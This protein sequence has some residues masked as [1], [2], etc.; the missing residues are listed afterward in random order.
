MGKKGTKQKYFAT[1][2][3][4]H[5]SSLD[6]FTQGFSMCT[7][8]LPEK[9]IFLTAL[10]FTLSLDKKHKHTDTH[11]HTDGKSCDNNGSYNKIV[12]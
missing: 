11:I 12:M 4:Q 5:I 9:F 6:I 2:N 3:S 10:L 8:C 7:A 1:N